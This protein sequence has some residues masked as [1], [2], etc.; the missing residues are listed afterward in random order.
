MKPFTEFVTSGIVKRQSPDRNRAGFLFLECKNSFR[1]L[2]E[3]EKKIALD[4]NSANLF[5]KSCYDILMELIRAHMLLAGYKAVGSGAHEAEV[6]YLNALGF[7][8]SDVRF[9]DQLRYFRNGMLYY[10][11]ILDEEYAQKVIAVTK[12]HFSTLRNAEIEP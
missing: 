5:I 11:T 10:G 2:L 4:S 12:K 6:A 1:L 9:L 8:E 7:A 3:M